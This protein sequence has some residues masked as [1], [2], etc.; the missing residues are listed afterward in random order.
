MVTDGQYGLIL[1]GEEA[2][3]FCEL[4]LPGDIDVTVLARAVE[5]P[6]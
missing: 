4:S 1:S 5:L 6:I 3:W 2:F